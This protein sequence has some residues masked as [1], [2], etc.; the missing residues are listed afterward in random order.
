[1][2]KNTDKKTV[3]SIVSWKRREFNQQTRMKRFF[4][5]LNLDKKD[6]KVVSL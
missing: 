1:V 4:Q 5:A 2:E 6:P 3:I